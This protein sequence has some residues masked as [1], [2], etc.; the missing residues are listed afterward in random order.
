MYIGLDWL[1]SCRRSSTGRFKTRVIIIS[2][3]YNWALITSLLLGLELATV[4]VVVVEMLLEVF[5]EGQRC[6]QKA[7][8]LQ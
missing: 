3:S 4:V 6:Q 2:T 1:H 5:L 7:W 8:A